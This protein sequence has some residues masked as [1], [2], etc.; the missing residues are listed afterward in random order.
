MASCFPLVDEWQVTL[1]FSWCCLLFLFRSRPWKPQH[2]WV[3]ASPY[4][5]S[6]THVEECTAC[7]RMS[8]R[9]SMYHYDD[10]SENPIVE[11]T[12]QPYDH[13]STQWRT[14]CR[15]YMR[16]WLTSSIEA[17]CFCVSHL[18]LHTRTG[19]AQP[20]RQ[21]RLLSHSVESSHGHDGEGKCWEELRL[22]YWIHG[23]DRVCSSLH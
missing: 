20:F 21:L 3:S 5:Y 16:D 23:R 2:S 8:S 17:L 15:I 7:R 9:H 11:C 18:R 13:R 6:Y 10:G 4:G 12:D 19:I 1:A 22:V 14:T